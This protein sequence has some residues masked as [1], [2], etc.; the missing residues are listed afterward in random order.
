MLDVRRLSSSITPPFP[1]AFSLKQLSLNFISL[2][3]RSDIWDSISSRMLF[4]TNF[5]TEMTSSFSSLRSC[6]LAILITSGTQNKF[7]TSATFSVY[8]SERSNSF[9]SM[10]FLLSLSIMP[11]TVSLCIFFC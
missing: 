1:F 6:L 2:M 4:I 3:T 8:M 11:K 5:F 9:I 10:S 7:S